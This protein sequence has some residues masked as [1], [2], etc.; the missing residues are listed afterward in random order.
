LPIP[1]RT[2][3]ATFQSTPFARRETITP[4][5]ALPIATFQSTPFARRETLQRF[6]D[7]LTPKV[8]QSTPFARRET[9]IGSC[10]IFFEIR[11][12]PL[13]SQEGRRIRYRRARWIGSFN[14]LPSQEGRLKTRDSNNTILQFQ[15]TPFARRET[16]PAGRTRVTRRVSIHSLRK[17]GDIGINT[18]VI[19]R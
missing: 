12:N 3:Q 4:N 16:R 19:V 13:P 11:F 2:R 1:S 9:R 7:Q 5:H 14:P 8:F 18:I 15:S 17:K 10:S 6:A